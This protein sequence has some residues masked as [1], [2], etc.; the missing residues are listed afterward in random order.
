MAYERS[1]RDPI[2]RISSRCL[3]Q[4]RRGASPPPLPQQGPDAGTMSPIPGQP[5]R[6][7]DDSRHLS[8]VFGGIFSTGQR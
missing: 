5:P 6:A 7:P 3:E 8:K 2:G 1:R 4:A